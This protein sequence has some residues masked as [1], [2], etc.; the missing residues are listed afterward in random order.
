MTLIISASHWAEP[1]DVRI[2]C[3]LLISDEDEKEE[4]K[5]EEDVEMSEEDDW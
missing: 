4:T 5:H 1:S 3:G 2:R